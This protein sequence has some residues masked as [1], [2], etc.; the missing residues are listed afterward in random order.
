MAD[1][2]EFRTRD[3]LSKEEM[4]EELCRLVDEGQD[5]IVLSHDRKEHTTIL[6]TT[7]NILEDRLQAKGLILEGQEIL[8]SINNLE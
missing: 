3:Q 2:R 1:I 6:G 5:V 4:K 7:I 8:L